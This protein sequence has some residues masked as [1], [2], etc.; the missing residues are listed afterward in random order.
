MRRGEELRGFGP[1]FLLSDGPNRAAYRRALALGLDDGYL[2]AAWA[3]FLLDQKRPADVIQAL[4][5]WESSDGLLL[6]LALAEAQLGLAKAVTHTQ[7]LEDRFA[8]ARQR[9][10]TTH[11]AEEAR[12]LLRLKRDT[13]LALKIAQANFQVQREPR[14]ARVLL[15]VAVAAGDASAA[16]AAREWLH[17]SGFEDAHLRSL[18]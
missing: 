3:D 13:A 8:A 5:K 14:D 18:A 17:S 11:R 10:D 7:V 12:F 4:E 2:L 9:N 6:R 16:Q 1:P 15:E